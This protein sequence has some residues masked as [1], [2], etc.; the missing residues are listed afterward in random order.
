ML[1]KFEASYI[2][3]AT[4]SLRKKA[5]FTIVIKLIEARSSA[6]IFLANFQVLAATQKQ[7]KQ[8]R[9]FVILIECMATYL[10]RTRS[11]PQSHQISCGGVG[12]Y[13]RQPNHKFVQRMHGDLLSY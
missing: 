8:E 9:D 3:K 6:N 1:F 13:E 4:K 5:D 2:K 12:R 7:G 11:L 10:F